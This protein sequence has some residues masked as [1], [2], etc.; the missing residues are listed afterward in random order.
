MSQCIH[1]F[2][3]CFQKTKTKI[4]NLIYDCSLGTSFEQT[5]SALSLHF[6][7]ELGSFRRVPCQPAVSVVWMGVFTLAKISVSISTLLLVQA[8]SQLS[9]SSLV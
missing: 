4:I 7:L 5:F 9:I 1:A 3:F 2:C 6:T 8:C